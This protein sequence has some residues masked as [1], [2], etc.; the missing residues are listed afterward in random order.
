[1][2]VTD[3]CSTTPLTAEMSRNRNLPWVRLPRANEVTL[4][5]LASATMSED[6]RSVP[7]DP[8][9]VLSSMLNVQEVPPTIW[10]SMATTVRFS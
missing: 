10:P 7:G 2:R 1:M 6:M 4:S 3:N 8:R 9:V 5:P